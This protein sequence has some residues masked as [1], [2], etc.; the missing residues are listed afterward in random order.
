[1][2]LSPYGGGTLSTRPVS[3][4]GRV[5]CMWHIHGPSS[6]LITG[7]AYLGPKVLR[8][9]GSMFVDNGVLNFGVS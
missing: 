9:V 2:V 8:Y 6:L 3:D 4:S 1:M 5:F 7:C